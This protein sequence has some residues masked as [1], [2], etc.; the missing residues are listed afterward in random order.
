LS[1]DHRIE[2][3]LLPVRAEA[4]CGDVEAGAIAPLKAVAADEFLAPRTVDGVAETDH[5]DAVG[6]RRSIERGAI[7]K[8]GELAL[9]AAGDPEVIHQVAAE[10]AARIREPVRLL[11]G[12]RV[13]QHPRRLERLRAEHHRAR[14]QLVGL[15]RDAIDVADA[16]GA[17]VIGIHHHL[18]DHRI[19]QQGA[20]AGRHRIRH[21]RKRRVEIRPRGAAPFAGTAVMTRASA[22]DGPGQVRGA[23][24]RDGATQL[25]LDARS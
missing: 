25:A 23:A 13:E 14:P 3:G 10:R 17:L 5:V 12:L 1:R 9:G 20:V 19:G 24:D 22:V 11:P 4:G 7:G 15:P 2:Q 6:T 18:R 21:G 8:I 16:D